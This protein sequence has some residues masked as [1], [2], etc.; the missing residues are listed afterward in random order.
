MNAIA[1]GY[2][3]PDEHS[4]ECILELFE[5]DL[6]R[7]DRLEIVYDISDYFEPRLFSIP[8]D[9]GPSLTQQRRAAEYRAAQ[10]A[11]KD[12]VQ[13][14]ESRQVRRARLRKERR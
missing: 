10:E 13:P 9:G 7:R 4:K 2:Q 5:D 6:R 12:I 1:P 14:P 8:G 11:S 3:Q